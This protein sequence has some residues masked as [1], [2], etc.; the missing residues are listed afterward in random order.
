MI[1]FRFRN[2]DWSFS[3]TAE[4]ATGLFLLAL[5]VAVVVSFFA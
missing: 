2:V 5:V 3:S 1:M 4:A